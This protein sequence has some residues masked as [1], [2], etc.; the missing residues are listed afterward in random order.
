[1]TVGTEAPRVGTAG[2]LYGGRVS[3]VTNDATGATATTAVAVV[4]LVPVTVVAHVVVAAID[5]DFLLLPLL[6]PQTW[7]AFYFPTPHS[8]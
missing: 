6:L 1:M 3:V 2:M 4:A 5:V 8:S 7:S